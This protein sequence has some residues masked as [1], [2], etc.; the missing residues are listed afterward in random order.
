[1]RCIP[2]PAIHNIHRRNLLTLAIETSCDD[3]SVAVLEKIGNK[4]TLHFHDKVTSDNRAA[5]GI[6]P[7]IAIESHQKSLGPL[8]QRALQTLPAQDPA[9]ANWEN[10][11]P[12]KDDVSKETILRKRP[13]FV[14]A[15]R[16]PGIYGS[17]QTGIDCAKGLAVAWD[18]PFLGVNH[19]QA[20]ALTPRLVS[21]L[22]AENESTPIAPAFPFLS[23]LVS[24]GNTMLVHAKSVL[25]HSIL[26][27]TGDTAIGNAMD[28]CAIHVLPPSLL[29]SSGTVSY[30]PLFEKY[31]F[32]NGEADYNYQAP[33]TKKGTNIPNVTP[34]GWVVTP[35]LA[36]DRP[37]AM[38]YTYS[39]IRS[40]VTRIASERPN[41][42]ETERR[43]LAREAQ[44]VAFEHVGSRAL[45]AL[46]TDALKDVKTL[47]VAGGVASNRFLKYVLRSMLDA[48]GFEDVELCFPP[49][50]LCTDNAAMIA[51]TGMEM[52]EEGW[53]SSL[54]VVGQR[55][56]SIDAGK[57]GGGILRLNGWVRRDG[58]D[59]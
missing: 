32:P 3:T 56:W 57:P 24:G 47:V 5:L 14:T 43:L 7:V 46:S 49:V 19:M 52:W 54:E 23:L 6:H 11:L 2:R 41:M 45:L 44:R 35:P 18:V 59:E 25:T 15:T 8:I 28:K 16:G 39:G 26:A 22:I 42:D 38:E 17:L 10:L 53:R 33:S 34:Y 51:W 31:A 37:Y 20:H 13:D 1:M 9:I 30:G 29:E 12:I 55:K 40:S 36:K 21:S 58:V 50:S 4:S 27:E 48:R